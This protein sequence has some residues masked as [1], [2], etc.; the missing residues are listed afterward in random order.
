METYSPSLEA[1]VRQQLQAAGPARLRELGAYYLK[2]QGPGLAL[3]RTEYRRR[4]WP[5]PVPPSV[6]P[7]GGNTFPPA[8]PRCGQPRHRCVCLP[9]LIET[10]RVATLAQ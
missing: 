6:M 2:R 7:A 10:A 5:D 3:L 9:F 8:C 1:S 4:G